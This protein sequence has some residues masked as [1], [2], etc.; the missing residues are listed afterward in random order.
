MAATITAQHEEALNLDEV[1]VGGSTLETADAPQRSKDAVVLYKSLAESVSLDWRYPPS[2]PSPADAE[3]LVT[4]RIHPRCKQAR[5][6]SSTSTR[7]G[8]CGHGQREWELII[9]EGPN[10]AGV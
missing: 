7:E 1:L 8:T 4:S 5:E 6:S 10:V 9:K 3:R 2:R